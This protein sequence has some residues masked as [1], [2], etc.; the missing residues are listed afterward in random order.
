MTAAIFLLAVVT[1]AARRRHRATAR[2]GMTRPDLLM[3]ESLHRVGGGLGASLTA[4][5]PDWARPRCQE[6]AEV[7]GRDDALPTLVAWLRDFSA[8]QH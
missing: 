8:C 5:L 2:P 6:F 4:M 3:P 1:S 7:F